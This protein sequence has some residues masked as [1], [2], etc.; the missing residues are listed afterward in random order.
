MDTKTILS[1]RIWCETKVFKCFY[2]T[3]LCFQENAFMSLIASNLSLA[4]H[5][6]LLISNSIYLYAMAIPITWYWH[7]VLFWGGGG[8]TFTNFLSCHSSP[9]SWSFHF[10]CAKKWSENFEL[11]NAFLHHYELIVGKQMV[12]GKEIVFGFV[13]WLSALPKVLN[14]TSSIH[15][16]IK[17]F[18]VIKLNSIFP[19]NLKHRYV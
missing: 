19:S 3:L 7:S 9:C 13:Q 5:H 1:V 8:L 14:R 4:F 11:K 10:F 18:V 16:F 15:A 17:P 12:F 6:Q 2:K